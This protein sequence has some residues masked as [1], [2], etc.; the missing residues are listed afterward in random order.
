M[1]KSRSVQEMREEIDE[2]R[3]RVETLE[4]QLLAAL[5]RQPYVIYTQPAPSTFPNTPWQPPPTITFTGDTAPRPP[6]DDTT[7]VHEVNPGSFVSEAELVENEFWQ[8]VSDLPGPDEAG[9]IKAQDD[10]RG[11]Y[12]P[13]PGGPLRPGDPP[14]AV[15]TQKD[16]DR[17]PQCSGPGYAHPPH[18]GCSGYSTDRT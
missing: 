1:G 7:T 8:R 10:V 6:R 18:G 16:I 3:A 5:L 15:G 14:V 13:H 4:G 17:D 12:V 9:A 11:T 2:L